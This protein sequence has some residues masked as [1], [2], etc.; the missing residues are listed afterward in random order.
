MAGQGG[1]AGEISVNQAS[2]VLRQ[3]MRETMRRRSLLYLVQGG[4]LVAAGAAA[5]ISPLFAAVGLIALLG[6]LLIAVGVI[7]ATGLWGT[8][9]VPYFWLQAVSAVLAVVVGWA[10][11]ARPDQ[12][13]VG[14]ALLMVVFFMVEGIQRIVLGLMIRPMEDWGWIL[15]SGILGIVLGIV[16]AA[17]LVFMAGWII[18]FLLGIHLIGAG[19]AIGWMAYKLRNPAAGR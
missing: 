5:L 3:A 2:A 4:V 15:G 12:G 11:I 13:L 14:V 8:R 10:L 7:E 9:H 16:L 17:N 18:G 6:W 1:M 19:G